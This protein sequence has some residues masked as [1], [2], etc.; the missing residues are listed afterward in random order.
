MA[1]QIAKLVNC[2]L[3]V[4]NVLLLQIIAQQ[5]AINYE[6]ATKF[7]LKDAE[8]YFDHIRRNYEDSSVVGLQLRGRTLPFIPCFYPRRCGKQCYTAFISIEKN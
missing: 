5:I 4:T 8:I 7:Y 1:H 3:W 6:M 2:H